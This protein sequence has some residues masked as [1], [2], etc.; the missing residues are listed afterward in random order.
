MCAPCWPQYHILREKGTEPPGSGKY[1]KFY[2]KGTY[3][4]AGCGAP[5]YKYVWHRT[6]A[7]VI[8]GAGTKVQLGNQKAGAVA[9][10]MQLMVHGKACLLSVNAAA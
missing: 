3:K 1:D 4:C 2:E 10:N 8:P 5:L 6:V 7:R 9:D